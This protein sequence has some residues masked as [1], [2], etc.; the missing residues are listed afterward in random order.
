MKKSIILAI[1]AMLT[2]GAKAQEKTETIKWMGFN[3]AIEAC[4]KEPKMIFI[5]VFTDWCG[6]CK[7]M[8]ATTFKN[9]VIAKYMNDKFYAVKFDAE[10]DR[11]SVV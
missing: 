5:D 6:W 10:R 8:D 4:K 2:F 1:F 11:K 3:E 9:P 7:R